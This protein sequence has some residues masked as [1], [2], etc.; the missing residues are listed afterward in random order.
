MFQQTLYLTQHT[1]THTHAHTCTRPPSLLKATHLKISIFNTPVI[2][3]AGIWTCCKKN[4]WI[5]L[6]SFHHCIALFMQTCHVFFTVHI[7]HVC[8]VCGFSWFYF[9]HSDWLKNSFCGLSSVVMTRSLKVLTQ[10]C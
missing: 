5:S 9:V 7:H 10:N 2:K 1:H 6:T 4:V 8:S 3:T